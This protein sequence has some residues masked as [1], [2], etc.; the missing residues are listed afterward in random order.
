[1]YA[2]C[3]IGSSAAAKFY[4]SLFEVFVELAYFGF[5]G[6]K[7]VVGWPQ[8]PAPVEE[9]AE[10]AEGFLIM[11]GCVSLGCGDVLMTQELGENVYGQT[12]R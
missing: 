3:P 8:C 7:V 10:V 6:F 1:M 9:A 11:D 12:S 2:W 4:L 5:R